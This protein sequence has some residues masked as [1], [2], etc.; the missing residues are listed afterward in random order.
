LGGDALSYRRT[1]EKLAANPAR[2]TAAARRSGGKEETQSAST[3]LRKAEPVH[4]ILVVDS[5][6]SMGFL[7]NGRTLF[8]SAREEARKIVASSSE[9]DL[10]NLVRI[11]SGA[12]RVRVQRPSSPTRHFLDELANLSVTYE[13]GDVAGTLGDVVELLK[14]GPETSRREVYILSDFQRS[15]WSPAGAV[16]Q[17]RIQGVM[18]QIVKAG[19]RV[20]LLDVGRDGLSNQAVVR[21][22]CAEPFPT[23]NRPVSIRAEIEQYGPRGGAGRTVQLHVDGK[24]ADTRPLPSTGQAVEMIDFTYTFLEAGEHK[25]EVRLGDDDLPM[26]N[27]RMLALPVREE[28]KVLLVDGRPTGE[29]RDQATYY[30]EKAL[31]PGTRREAWTGITRPTR[32][33]ERELITTDLA[34]FDCLFLCDVGRLTGRE[35][36]VLRDYVEAGGG[37]VI[38][39]GPGLDIANYN[40]HLFA[41][42]K[43]LLP[44][45]LV[46]IVSPARESPTIF[47]LDTSSLK[48]PLV[49]SF[50]GNTGTGLESSLAARYLKVEIPAESSTRTVLSFDN[51]DPAI[52]ETSF[53]RGRVVLVTT[54]LDMKWGWWPVPPSFLPLIQDFAY[55]LSGGRWQEK[56]KLIGE[57]I[58]RR[59]PL[60]SASGGAVRSASLRYPLNKRKE[61]PP[62]TG[63]GSISYLFEETEAPG[64]YELE[65][66]PPISRL[67]LFSVNVDPR[68]SDPGR[69]SER[70]V[71]SRISQEDNGS[72][73]GGIE[74]RKQLQSSPNYAG[75]L[76]ISHDVTTERMLLALG[77]LVLV[78]LAMAWRI[79]LGAVL[80]AGMLVACVVVWAGGSE[81]L[82]CGLGLLCG[83]GLFVAT[84]TG[85]VPGRMGLGVSQFFAKPGGKT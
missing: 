17:A 30:I 79:S 53:G 33:R 11:G 35:A 36:N 39:P 85:I 51:R 74:F 2:T 65:A 41:G 55:F 47:S 80:L 59:Y 76:Q 69:V 4:R 26:D 23:R 3:R 9:D 16:E 38:A 14:T 70:E 22:N 37:L 21:L 81:L 73:G 56:Q 40:E 67:E 44:A 58:S 49:N 75:R 46:S 45:R 29:P 7:R 1:Q 43:P 24:L 19:G 60:R 32:I 71:M 48:H 54:S 31:A 42:E 18:G 50:E 27:Q 25:V 13:Y 28:L 62:R 52:L 63:S 77:A 57:S 82:G 15:N 34:G 8:E 66:G 68:E 61:L 5:S 83:G 84:R 64:F 72:D 20:I 12:N 6:L 78:E 10:L